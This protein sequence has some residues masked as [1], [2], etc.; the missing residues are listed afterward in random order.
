MDFNFFN[1]CSAAGEL[2]ATVWL[3]AY[4]RMDY[5]ITQQLNYTI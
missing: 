1:Y 4:F 2:D 3:T 5:G